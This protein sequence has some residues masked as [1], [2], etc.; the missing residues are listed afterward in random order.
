[1]VSQYALGDVLDVA[2]FLLETW[3][4]ILDVT[5][6]SNGVQVVAASAEKLE[7]W[8]PPP[9]SQCGAIMLRAITR[10]SSFTLS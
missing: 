8:R 9:R 4:A 10:A 2:D 7:W 3:A 6:N 5:K 1:M